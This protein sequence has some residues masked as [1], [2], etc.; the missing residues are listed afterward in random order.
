SNTTD[1]SPPSYEVVTSKP[2]PYY[3]LF[4]SA[5]PT[6]DEIRYAQIFTAPSSTP[7]DV[8][9]HTVRRTGSNEEI[10]CYT[11]IEPCED[12]ELPSYAEAVAPSAVITWSAAT[13]EAD[14][15]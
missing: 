8:P 2:P 15:P 10:K 7:L 13:P 1:D 5:P 12:Q 6:G 14:S 4:A 11:W 9:V 3:V